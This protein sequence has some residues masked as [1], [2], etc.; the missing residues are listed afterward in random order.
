[1]PARIQQI[2]TL[3]EILTWMN[4]MEEACTGT[5]TRSMQSCHMST[6]FKKLE[7]HQRSKCTT[8]LGMCFLGAH[9]NFDVYDVD[10]L[11]HLQIIPG[12]ESMPPGC[13]EIKYGWPVVSQDSFDEMMWE[14]PW[15]NS[16]SLVT[17]IIL[18]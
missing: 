4:S 7:H 15:V 11:E 1:M 2:P 16:T 13:C 18:P 6:V 14:C 3:V 8:K 5:M 12:R 17:I 10:N 9:S